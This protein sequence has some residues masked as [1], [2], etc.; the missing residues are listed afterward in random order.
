MSSVELLLYELVDPKDEIYIFLFFF[1]RMNANLMKTLFVLFFAK[2]DIIITGSSKKEDGNI[3]YRGISLNKKRK[4][5][6]G[7]LEKS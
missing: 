7:A 4:I 5:D 3:E 2:D 6:L 1:S